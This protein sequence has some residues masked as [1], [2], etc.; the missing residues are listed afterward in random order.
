MKFLKSTIF[1]LLVF[2]A[3]CD[4][5][6]NEDIKTFAAPKELMLTKS[7]IEQCVNG[8]Y[9]PG[10]DFYSSK[11]FLGMFSLSTDEGLTVHQA[12]Q[13]AWA[14]IH[15]YVHNA[16]N[17]SVYACWQANVK[18]I[19]YA[20]MVLDNMPVL[21]TLNISGEEQFLNYKKGEALFLRALY[22]Y[23]QVM[24][25]GSV[26]LLTELNYMELY[27]P[28]APVEEIFARIINDLTEAEGLLPGWKDQLAEAGR[29]TRGAAK[30]LLGIVYLSRAGSD[31]KEPVDYQEAAAKFKE[32][33][34]NE[35]YDLWESY[36]DVF[37]PANKNKKEDIFSWQ[38]EYGMTSS[39]F[40]NYT[41]LTP[42]P[43]GWEGAGSAGITLSLYQAFEPNDERTMTFHG[44]PVV[45]PGL[46]AGQYINQRTGGVVYSELIWC[47]KFRDPVHA[48]L[49]NASGTNWPLIRYAD[50]LLSYAEALNEVNNGPNTEAYRAMNKVRE[51]AG[52]LPL[53]GLSKQAF[54]DAIVKE[55]L[56]ELYLEGKRFYD[57][58]RWGLL[59]QKVEAD[60][61]VDV[62]IPKHL[63]FPIP[64]K[65]LDANYDLVQNEYW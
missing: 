25:F 24:A 35:G 32:V 20:N 5:F 33:I 29:P 14:D 50:V 48:P 63:Y 40:N 61:D 16:S 28:K 2:V 42:N 27:H 45:L 37:L 64:Q 8:I 36:S 57:L 43:D 56:T 65:E 38:F 23:Q 60:R 49:G 47:E 15:Y 41:T 6:L 59:E 13:T 51:R 12:G 26:P 53:S 17:E 9:L 46:S 3:G 62:K 19:S 1:I 22:Y 34:D 55:R 39:P 10:Y 54:F 4:D 30:S 21:G 7:G 52:I 58:K 31:A 18:G 11:F 44:G